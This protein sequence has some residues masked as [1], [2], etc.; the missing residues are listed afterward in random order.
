MP[1]P[2]VRVAMLLVEHDWAQPPQWLGLPLVSISQPSVS[3][4]LLQSA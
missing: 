3:L 1:E 2:Q 4:L